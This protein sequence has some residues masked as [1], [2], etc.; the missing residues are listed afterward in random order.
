MAH[1]NPG[2]IAF[3]A[4]FPTAGQYRLFLQ[5]AHAGAV[6]TV[7]FDTHVEYPMQGTHGG[8]HV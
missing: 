4:E 6:K 3:H 7:A 2:V 8:P 5:F 1:S